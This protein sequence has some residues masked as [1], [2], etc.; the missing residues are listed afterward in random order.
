MKTHHVTRIPGPVPSR[1]WYALAILL[2]PL[3]LVAVWWQR[4]YPDQAERLAA[5]LCQ[6]K[7]R[8]LQRQR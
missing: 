6:A 8:L 1:C 2:L 7:A 4:R 5:R 3:A